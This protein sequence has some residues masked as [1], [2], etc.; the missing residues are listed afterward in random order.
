MK[1]VRYRVLGI[2]NNGNRQMMYP[3]GEYYFPNAIYVIEYPIL[4]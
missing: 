2:D 4:K 1:G 3:E